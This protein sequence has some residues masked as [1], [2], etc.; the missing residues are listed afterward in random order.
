MLE[1]NLQQIYDN[2]ADLKNVNNV[3]L[4]ILRIAV[5]FV[6]NFIVKES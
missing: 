6:Q 4:K 3:N 5:L 2:Y 1:L